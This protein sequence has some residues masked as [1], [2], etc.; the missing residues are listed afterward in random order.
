MVWFES[1][2]LELTEAFLSAHYA[3]MRIGST[4]AEA[5]T[6][7]ERSASPSITIDHLDFRF[8]MSYDVDPLGTIALCDVASGAVEDHGPDG[9]ATTTFGPGDLLTLAPP[10][11][12]YTGTINHAAYT[13]TMV[14]PALLGQVALPAKGY[15]RVELLHHR[16]VDGAAAGRLRAAIG[17]LDEVVLADP[18]SAA[19]PLVLGAASRYV[20][21]QLLAAFPNTAAAAGQAADSRDA[22]PLALRRALAYVE[23]NVAEDV[24]P[25]AMAAAAHVSVRALQLAFRRHLDTTPMAYLRELR[26]ARV[27]AQ[28]VAAVAGDGTTVGEVAA[29]WGFSH[30]GHFGVAYRRAYGETPSA[31]L[32][33][34]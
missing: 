28:L 6:R 3:P 19:N 14:D 8:E 21:A 29:R 16:P 27:R 23:A 13:I 24:S 9:S 4:T 15:D 26:M 22:H 31:T 30:Q 2:E 17:H 34:G 11:R 1:D 20:A 25:A 5:R 10:E 7:I 32:R 33:R 12:G 18:V